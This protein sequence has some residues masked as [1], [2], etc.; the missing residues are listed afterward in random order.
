MFLINQLICF[1][2][3]FNA[4]DR[5]KCQVSE[6]DLI[7]F[8]TENGDLTIPAGD[9][10]GIGPIYLRYPFPFFKSIQN[11][12]YINTNG[13]ISFGNRFIQ[14]TSTCNPE[15]DTRGKFVAPFWAGIDTNNGRGG[16]VYFRETVKLE[17]L[18]KISKELGKVFPEFLGI[19][20][21]SLVIATWYGVT[22][23]GADQCQ[24]QKVPNNTFQ[25]I[26]AT[27]GK[28]SFAIFYY[29]QVSWS[30]SNGHICTGVGGTSA[31]VGID[32]GEGTTFIDITDSCLASVIRITEKHFVYPGGRAYQKGKYYFRVDASEKVTECGSNK[33]PFISPPYADEFGNRP[34]K[35]SGPCFSPI[36]RINCTFNTGR[37]IKT[38]KAKLIDADGPLPKA[39]CPMPYFYTIRE[40]DRPH[41]TT[42]GLSVQN[43]GSEPIV[44]YFIP[45]TINYDP[46]TL[47]TIIKRQDCCIT[48]K[49]IWNPSYFEPN[50]FNTY[51]QIK[52][53]VYNR[54]EWIDATGALLTVNTARGNANYSVQ[55]NNIA[56]L[57]N[58]AIVNNGFVAFK[59]DVNEGLDDDDFPSTY[60]HN[61][62]FSELYCGSMFFSTDIGQRQQTCNDWFKT[63]QGPPNYFSA[64]SECPPTLR[65]ANF[66]WRFERENPQ[67][68]TTNFELMT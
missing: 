31:K 49:F 63:D 25:A 7:P 32:P 41:Q 58:I 8:G 1:I 29:N 23:K 24:Y 15:S 21:T 9:T 4:N 47:Q 13:I 53:I 40:A 51:S 42:I 33:T 45:L 2:L 44:N 68:G 36:A 12:L 16:A 35:I 64:D 67:K 39:V 6:T 46:P 27:D 65:K 50:S 26:L 22:Y 52:L 11:R 30:S 37:G 3:L 18:Q 38:F 54:N 59:F 66:D 56:W 48:I 19:K 14:Y 34:L 28:F 62:A 61:S 20:I 57:V 43:S 60:K 10:S 55:F 5:A 17:I